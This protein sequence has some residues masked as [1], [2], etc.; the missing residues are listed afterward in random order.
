M[1]S[2]SSSSDNNINDQDPVLRLPLMEAELATLMMD[3]SSSSS[4]SSSE[5]AKVEELKTSIADAKTA[6][7]FGVRKS[8]LQFYGAFS[9]G[10][11]DAM[12][13][14][15]SDVSHVRCVHPG[16]ASLEGRDAVMESWRQILTPPDDDDDAPVFDIEPERVQIEI[17]G[18]TAICSCVERTQNGGQLEAINVYKRENGSWKMT[19]HQ[20]GPVMMASSIGR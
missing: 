19:L 4:S 8:Q 14:V 12:S 2:S 3:G 5:N 17:C 1:A 18:S 16:M 11:A 10:D 9:A 15:W 7:E 20:A 6:A 13:G